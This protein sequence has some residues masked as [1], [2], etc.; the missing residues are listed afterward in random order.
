MTSKNGSEFYEGVRAA[1]IDKDKKPKWNPSSIDKVSDVD[2]QKHFIPI[3]GQASLTL[4]PNRKH[5]D[6]W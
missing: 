6:K 3:P 1:L 5:S 4:D 2:V